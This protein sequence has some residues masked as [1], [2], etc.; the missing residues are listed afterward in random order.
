MNKANQQECTAD[1]HRKKE[2]K[3]ST[4]IGHSGWITPKI[5]IL[6]VVLKGFK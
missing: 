3:S 2:I 4:I 1:Q 5:Q 6:F